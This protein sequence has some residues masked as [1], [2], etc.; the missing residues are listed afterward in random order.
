MDER[1]GYRRHMS[2]L[3]SI[4]VFCHDPYVMAPFWS[5]ALGLPP[6]EEDADKLASRSLGPL[7]SVLLHREG[8]PQ[9]WVTPVEALD[10]PGNR[11]H[12]DVSG[13]PDL[14]RH[15]VELGGRHVRDE[16]RWTVVSDPE[17]NQLCVVPGG[18]PGA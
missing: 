17:G 1:G 7:E 2:G 14:V 15:L 12:V 4:V 18:S 5:A 3:H 6:V 9:V 16:Q 8:H 10:P 11:L 13:G